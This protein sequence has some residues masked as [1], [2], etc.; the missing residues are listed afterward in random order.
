MPPL[1][2]VAVAWIAGLV[3]ARHWLVPL[4]VSPLP[5]AL[6]SLITLVATV[7]ARKDRSM[8]LGSICALALLLGALRYQ[9]SVPDLND[10]E[11]VAHYNNG[12]W[13]ALEGVVDG[14]PDI[15]D[16]WTNLK[17]RV[18]SIEINGQQR[19]VHG[20]VLVRAPRY[21][22]HHY[23]DRLRV[24]GLLETPPEFEGFSYRDYLERK[25]VYSLVNRPQIEHLASDQGSPFWTLLF[26]VKD[27]ARD[28]IARLMPD[29]EA[30]LLQGILLGIKTGIPGDL[31][32]DYNA[33]GTSHII[34]ISGANITIVAALF[35]QTF[36]RIVGKRRAYWFTIA[37]II[38]YVLLVGADAVVVRA[39]LM[40][41]LFV[42]ALYLGRRSTAYVS[43]FAS[44]AALTAINPQALW[45]VGFVS[46]Q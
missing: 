34:V 30:S 4:G 45:D 33:T 5:L 18:K 36:G 37:G 25:G 23:G 40:G 28:V 2:F 6:L 13:S 1:V 26:A 46:I 29:P 12:D 15:R 43:L 11:F 32:D 16:T 27:R 10:P 38:L 14:Y 7:W 19:P 17:L 24:S 9:A 44:A 20:E 31:Y 41:A 21:P 35:S 3:V 8:L 42:T 22:E 39:G